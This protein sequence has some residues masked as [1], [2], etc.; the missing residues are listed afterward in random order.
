MA[1]A[2]S[3][4]RLSRTEVKRKRRPLSL[5]NISIRRIDSGIEVTD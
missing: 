3:L 2:A 1:L 4:Y 5:W